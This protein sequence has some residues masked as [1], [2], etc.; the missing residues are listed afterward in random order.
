MTKKK[1]ENQQVDYIF[2][3]GNSLISWKSPLQKNVTLSTAEVEFVGLTEC[4]NQAL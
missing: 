2:L 3:F 4:T 1:Q